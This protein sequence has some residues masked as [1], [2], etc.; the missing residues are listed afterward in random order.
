MYPGPSKKSPPRPA[1][2]GPATEERSRVSSCGNWEWQHV[3][4][5]SPGSTGHQMVQTLY[6]WVWIGDA[7]VPEAERGEKP[8]G[9][10][11]PSSAPPKQ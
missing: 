1:G 9:G 8:P 5:P 7:S 11:S 6:G 4:G 2:P 10:L 3:Q